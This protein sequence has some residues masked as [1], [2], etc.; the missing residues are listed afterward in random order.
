MKVGVVDA[1]G[2]LRGIYSAGIFDYLMD[3]DIKFDL[4]IGVSAG[5][6]NI[7]SFC[8]NQRGRN[9]L[10]Y[11]EYSQRKEY[12]SL[13]NF[14][15]KRSYM[16]M[17][18]IYGTLT[19][20]GGENPLDYSK[21]IKNPMKFI[22]VATNAKTGK[23]V[24]FSKDDMKP[25]RYDYFKASCSIPFVCKPQIIKNTPYY[26]GALGDPIPIKKAIEWGCD[27]IVLILTKPENDIRTPDGDIHLAKRIKKKYPKSAAAIAKRADNYNAGVELAKKLR[28]KGKLLIVSPDDTCGVRTLT[29]DKTLLNKLYKKGYND[30]EKIKEFLKN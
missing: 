18:Y 9:Y 15:F 11:A 16:D 1:G 25:D 24:Y 6:A 28:D 3:K 2:G 5:C 13:K 29:K 4:G 10:F 27:K 19:N 7:A 22:I 26:D 14:I 17:D 21:F 23:P 8:A 12:M 30:G 20:R